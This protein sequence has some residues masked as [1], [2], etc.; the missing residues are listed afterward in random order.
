M[1]DTYIYN[2]EIIYNHKELDLDFLKEDKDCSKCLYLG[3]V[4]WDCEHAQVLENYDAKYTDDCFWIIEIKK[5]AGR[6]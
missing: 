2:D 1:T 5:G 6:Q 3:F 4:C